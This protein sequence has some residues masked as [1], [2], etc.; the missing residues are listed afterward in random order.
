MGVG[1]FSALFGN[2][3]GAENLT[4]FGG[5]RAWSGYIGLITGVVQIAVSFG[6][7]GMKKWAWYLTLVGVSLSVITGVIGMFSGG[8]FG[9]ICGSIGL[10]IPLIV[11]FY[12]LSKDIRILFGI[13]QPE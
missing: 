5:E 10:I 8:L 12:I 2:L 13:S 4:A 1:G 7:S 3:F 9:F 11:L 6:L